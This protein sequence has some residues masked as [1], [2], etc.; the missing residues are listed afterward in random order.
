MAA[1][2]VTHSLLSA[3]LYLLKGNPYE[4]ATSEADPMADFMRVLRREPTPKTEAME[5][6]VIFED[7]VTSILQ[8]E[9]NFGFYEVLDVDYS[10]IEPAP[11]KEHKW[12]SAAYKVATIVHGGQ[13]QVKAKKM[14][15]VRGMD[16]LLYG[17]LDAL[18]AGAIYDIKFSKSYDRGKYFTST[19]H[20]IY[21][22]LVPE[23][24][25]FSYLV[26]NGTDVWTETYRRE[27]VK[28]IHPTI[29][30]FF[31]W[32]DAVGLMDTYKEHWKAL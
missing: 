24:E 8:S 19:Q 13:L 4:D 15:V 7:L 22:E 29:S 3:W 10:F 2:M 14:I 32:L 12:H 25:S 5:N 11:T 30:D 31:D 18:R 6:G 1:Y 23:A 28:S 16:V 20:P 9:P 26:S 17:R 21:L 27:E